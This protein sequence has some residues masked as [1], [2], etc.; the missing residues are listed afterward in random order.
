MKLKLL[1][2]LEVKKAKMQT[3]VNKVLSKIEKVKTRIEVL[4]QKQ[5]KLEKSIHSERAFRIPGLNGHLSYRKQG[6]VYFATEKGYIYF[7][8]KDK[9]KIEI[10]VGE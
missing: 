3:K 1:D 9:K 4:Q 5:R 10:K 6:A 8:D 7:F 2:V